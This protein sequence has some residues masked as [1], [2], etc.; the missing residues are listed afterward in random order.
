M[1]RLHSFLKIESS[2]GSRECGMLAGGTIIVIFSIFEWSR[3][4]G[5]MSCTF[6]PP[7]TTSPTYD[8]VVDQSSCHGLKIESHCLPYWGIHYCCLACT[9]EMV[10]LE[11]YLLQEVVD[12]LSYDHSGQQLPMT[13]K[14]SVCPGGILVLWHLSREGDQ[15]KVGLS[16]GRLPI[17]NGTIFLILKMSG[18]V[19]ARLGVV[20]FEGMELVSK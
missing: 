10:H 15:L 13:P 4:V 8:C 19:K 14:A 3:L 16:W 11:D 2:M 9:C 18:S 17:C 6:S 1:V 20:S 12:R 5:S 7:S